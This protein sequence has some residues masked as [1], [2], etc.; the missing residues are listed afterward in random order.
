MGLLHI[1]RFHNI[2]WH[3]TVKVGTILY[4]IDS[5][6]AATNYSSYS[7]HSYTCE[8]AQVEI[9][10]YIVGYFHRVLIF[11]TDQAVTKISTHENLKEWV[12][13]VR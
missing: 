7:D 13:V 9:P 11:V 10:Y 6:C 3:N 5:Y 1:E 12:K 4:H 8:C 2:A